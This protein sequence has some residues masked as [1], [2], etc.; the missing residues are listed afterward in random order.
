MED[1]PSRM[2]E[3]L[4]DCGAGAPAARVD[5]LLAC[6]SAPTF[7]PEVDTGIHTLMVVDQSARRGFALLVRFRH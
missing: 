7:I 1:Q 3:V 4:R 2:I 5:K 6:R